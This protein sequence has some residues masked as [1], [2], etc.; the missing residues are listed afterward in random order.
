M[1]SP[2]SPNGEAALS[3]VERLH[4]AAFPVH[5][6]IFT[7]TGVRCDCAAGADCTSIGK[8][9]RTL[10]GV[11]DASRDPEQ[12]RRWWT[13]CRDANIGIATGAPSG[14][15]VMDFDNPSA[16]SAFRE[17]YGMP[18]T[19]TAITGRL[20]GGWH[21]LFQHPGFRISSTPGGLGAGID[22]RAD[23][24]LIVAT[25]S[26]HRS[27]RRYRWDT[28]HGMD[29]WQIMPA[30]MPPRLLEDLRALERRPDPRPLPLSTESA[31]DQ[32]RALEA[33]AHL[34][35]W[36]ADDYSSWLSVGMA[37]HAVDAGLLDA[38]DSWSTS[39]AK[40]RDNACA[41]KWKS[42][43]GTGIG[44]G[45]LLH[46]AEQDAPGAARSWWERRLKGN[47]QRA[48][49]YLAEYAP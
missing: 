41:R 24:A 22:I 38:W 21:L 25:P 8:H 16:L 28:E 44:L 45:S 18:P 46:W 9:P 14:L 23:G 15:A 3:Y 42:F 36:R 4:W 32:D 27:G 30:P 34:A 29:P 7:P 33:L 20:E 48:A 12:I 1:N 39:S 40:Y 26:L 49:T 5:T 31:D 6:P 19:V 35:A 11:K 37:L 2:L 17:R 10:H 13:H 43:R 47:A